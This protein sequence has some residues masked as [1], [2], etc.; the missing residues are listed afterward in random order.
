MCFHIENPG[1][2]LY[3]PLEEYLGN[4]DAPPV[5]VWSP[6]AAQLACGGPEPSPSPE[7]SPKTTS[8]N[9]R[10]FPNI[11]SY[12]LILSC[13]PLLI[14]TKRCHPPT[15]SKKDA[16]DSDATPPSARWPS[17]TQCGL[18]MVGRRVQEALKPF[19]PFSQTGGIVFINFGT[20]R[21]I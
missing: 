15:S 21:A 7:P 20:Q 11:A 10:P 12:S 14:P 5:G 3:C 6:S 17:P 1:S 9:P 2:G 4:L 8:S 18:P 13:T 16:S 19:S